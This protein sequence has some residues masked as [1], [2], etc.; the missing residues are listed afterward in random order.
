MGS[1]PGICRDPG[2]GPFFCFYIFLLMYVGTRGTVPLDASPDL[3]RRFLCP[4]RPGPGQKCA[5]R[6]G[7][8][9]VFA[10]L[11]RMV[12]PR[13]KRDLDKKSRECSVPCLSLVRTFRFESQGRTFDSHTA[14]KR[15]TKDHLC[16]NI[17]LR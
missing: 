17:S 13:D 7:P 1:C 5:E 11:S 10:R 9:E 6:V 3:S 14:L 12:I 16:I 4:V 2:P 8:G 15:Y